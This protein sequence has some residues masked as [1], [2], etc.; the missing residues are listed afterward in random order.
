VTTPV[1]SRV[2]RLGCALSL[3]VCAAAAGDAAAG[4]RLCTSADTL[5]FGDRPVGSSTTRRAVVSSCGDAPLRFTEVA[6]HPATGPAFHVSTD[7][8][9]GGSLPAGATC[10]VDVT[11]TPATAGQASGALWLHNDSVTP[12]QLVT[13]YARG[14]DAAAGTAGLA[15]E[16]AM[17][18]FGAVPQGER[19]GPRTLTLRNVGAAPLVPSALV[20]NGPAAF[21]FS[22][23][24]DGRGSIVVDATLVAP[25]V[26][27][28]W[29]L[30][31]AV[32]CVPQGQDALPSGA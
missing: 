28:G 6:V 17:L 4:A 14:A 29:V 32:L 25:L 12:D 24:G 13:F 7:C 9:S 5:V 20:L 11:F 10:S 21:D 1:A 3:L 26:A 19:A 18:D 27:A 16:P 22:T 2:R 8:A 31:G 30:E 15:F 23:P